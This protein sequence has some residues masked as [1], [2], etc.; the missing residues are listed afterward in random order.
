MIYQGFI[1]PMRGHEMDQE[2]GIEVSC[3][4]TD[5]MF[6]HKTQANRPG[7]ITCRHPDKEHYLHTNP[8]PI[9]RMDWQRVASL[10]Q[11]MARQAPR[12]R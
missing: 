9:Y 10:A 12:R 1:N 3:S 7:M 11:D 8:C 4:R 2:K 6:Y 5:C